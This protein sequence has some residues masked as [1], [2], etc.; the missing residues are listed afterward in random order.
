M[1][2]F[3]HTKQAASA[4]TSLTYLTTGALTVVWTIIWYLYLN[5][6][7]AGPNTYLWVY[8]FMMMGGGGCPGGNCGGG[9]CANGN[10]GGGRH[11]R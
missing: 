2:L 7:G 1:V 3:G 11:R 9:G 10:C 8:G 6:N 5:R 4:K